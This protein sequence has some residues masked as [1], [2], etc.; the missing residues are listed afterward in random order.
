VA[1]LWVPI[2]RGCLANLSHMLLSA[3]HM[4]AAN[5]HLAVVD[6]LI[7][8]GAVRKQTLY[9]HLYHVKCHCFMISTKAWLL[10]TLD[11]EVSRR[12]MTDLN[13]AE[14][15]C[16]QLGE[17]HTPPLGM[18][19]RAYRGRLQA[20]VLLVPPTPPPLRITNAGNQ[21]LDISWGKC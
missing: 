2:K 13:D 15:R 1:S 17:E 21:G 5:G 18:P 14:C 3:L 12:F 20:T 8:N 11:S 16:H 10:S 7:E 9:Y 6:Y 4:A 19:Q